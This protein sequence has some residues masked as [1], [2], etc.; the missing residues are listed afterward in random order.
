MAGL[1][2]LGAYRLPA[3][4]ISAYERQT[5]V[6]AAEGLAHTCWI[7]YADFES[8]LGPDGILFPGPKEE[9]RW[10][11]ALRVWE[12]LGEER[13][14]PGTGQAEPKGVGEREY[15]YTSTSYLLRPEVCLFAPLTP[16][17]SADCTSFKTVESFYILWRLTGETKWRERGWKIF[18]AIQKHARTSSGYASVADVTRDEIVLKDDMPSF[19]LAETSVS[20]PILIVG[21]FADMKHKF[22]ISISALH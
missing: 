4:A 5:H 15:M 2:A 3:D 9:N 7:T 10:V 8:G 21:S 16:T 17:A 12:A 14:P 6:W 13:R 20:S 1:L 19:F 11:N 18:Q 22:E